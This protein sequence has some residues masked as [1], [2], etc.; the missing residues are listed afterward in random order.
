MTVLCH[1]RSHTHALLAMSRSRS[2]VDLEPRDSLVPRVIN[3]SSR[4]VPAVTT[5]RISGSSSAVLQAPWEELSFI[6]ELDVYIFSDQGEDFE[7][8]GLRHRYNR[9][10]HQ[11]PNVGCGIW[12]CSDSR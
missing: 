12:R 9:G 3:N 6:P 11:P 8:G 4:L 2:V 10:K 1:Y 7:S 5:P